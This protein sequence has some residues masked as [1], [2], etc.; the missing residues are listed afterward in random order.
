MTK[1]NLKNYNEMVSKINAMSTEEI[2][3][4]IAEDNCPFKPEFLLEVPMGMFHCEVCGEMVV[5]GFP[6]PRMK[7]LPTE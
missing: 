7:D 3:K 5:A 4:L 2:D 6:H 1:E